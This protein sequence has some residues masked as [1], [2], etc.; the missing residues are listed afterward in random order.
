MPDRA[1]KVSVGPNFARP[2]GR[3]CG[4]HYV[5]EARHLPGRVHVEDRQRQEVGEDEV[6]DVAG[7]QRVTG[8]DR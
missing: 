5:V 6:L 1:R 3:C 7:R 8:A 2:A 4:A